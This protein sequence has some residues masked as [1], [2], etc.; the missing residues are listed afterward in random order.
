M[1]SIMNSEKW[2]GGVY[3]IDFILNTMG[4]D[5]NR[6]GGLVKQGRKKI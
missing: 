3:D 2:A 1:G 6:A 4:N 5:C